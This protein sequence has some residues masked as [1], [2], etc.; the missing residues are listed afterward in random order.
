[1]LNWI[2]EKSNN[3]EGFISLISLL[4]TITGVLLGVFTGFFKW[5]W[6]KVNPKPTIIAAAITGAKY[7]Q[8][9]TIE[10]ENISEQ[11]V[12][13]HSANLYINT[14][15]KFQIREGFPIVLQQ[16]K[17]Q[18]QFIS[19]LPG[20]NKETHKH[21]E[22]KVVFGFPNKKKFENSIFWKLDDGSINTSIKYTLPS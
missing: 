2:I 11:K 13:I 21:L 14:G 5:L 12:L 8:Q 22:L 4:I 6:K 16:E 17:K 15:D 7:P 1:M 20:S 10:F 9:V 18:L 19:D 3:N